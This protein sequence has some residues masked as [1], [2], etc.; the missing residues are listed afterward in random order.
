MNKLLKLLIAVFFVSATVSASAI[1]YTTANDD[2]VSINPFSLIWGQLNA[3]WEHKM[4]TNNSISG[5][6]GLWMQES[7]WNA[8]NIGASYKWYLDLFEEGKKSLNGLAVGPRIDMAYWFNSTD[9][10]PGLERDNFVSFGIGG[11]VSYK[12]VFGSG[13]WAVEPVIKYTIP[14]VKKDY[15]S[16]NDYGL[17]VNIGYCF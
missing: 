13:K 17:G 10:Q 7:D 9:W 2:V 5:N 16:P 4:G 8:F 14:L 3:Q 15:V 11:E 12:W 1:E 6:A